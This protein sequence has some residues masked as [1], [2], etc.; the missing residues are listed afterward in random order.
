VINKLLQK[1]ALTNPGRFNSDTLKEF[2]QEEIIMIKDELTKGNLIDNRF[3][4][5]EVDSIATLIKG[6]TL[7]MLKGSMNESDI[8]AFSK[9]LDE[10]ILSHNG[11]RRLR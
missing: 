11:Y 1:R 4:N 2:L 9:V 8:D 10:T 5:L 6:D 3:T 7:N